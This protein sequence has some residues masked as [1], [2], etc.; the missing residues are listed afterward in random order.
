MIARVRKEIY[1]DWS[2]VKF[3]D[4]DWKIIKRTIWKKDFTLWKGCKKIILENTF[5]TTIQYEVMM[6]NNLMLNKWLCGK[7]SLLDFLFPNKQYS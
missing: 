3:A 5:D 2:V 1:C 6:N 7:E 4:F